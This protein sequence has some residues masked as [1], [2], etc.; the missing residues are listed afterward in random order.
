MTY[1]RGSRPVLIKNID[2]ETMPPF[3]CGYIVSAEEFGSDILLSVR[4]PETTS[5]ASAGSYKFVFNGVKSIQADY[6]GA[7]NKAMCVLGLCV[8]DAE[9]DVGPV[10]D[11]WYLDAGNRQFGIVADDPTGAY[12]DGSTVSKLIEV[13][14]FLPQTRISGTISGGSTFEE[15]TSLSP[16]T[17][18]SI[19]GIDSEWSGAS[20]VTVHNPLGLKLWNGCHAFA[21]FNVSADRWEVYAA[22]GD[23]IVHGVQRDDLEL[24]QLDGD[25]GWTTWADLQAC[26][27]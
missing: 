17:F 12:V 23:K 26:P 18:G 19:G 22:T 2:T 5:E 20:T 24:Q 6:N 8:E 4:R 21:H 14:N 16:H 3:A 25:S 10:V 15:A 13:N 11:Q 27:E 9:G 7:G 1:Q